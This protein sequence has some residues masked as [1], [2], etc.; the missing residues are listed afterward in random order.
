MKL[1]LWFYQEDYKRHTLTAQERD[2]I[3]TVVQSIEALVNVMADYTCDRG[4]KYKAENCLPVFDVLKWLIEP[5]EKYLTENAG[6]DTPAIFNQGVE[7]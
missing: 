4:G 2:E 7:I 1:K 5:V 3:A 6:E